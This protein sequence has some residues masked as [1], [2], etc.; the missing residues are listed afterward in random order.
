[1]D[2]LV[3]E[4]QN[5]S[6]NF[7]D[8]DLETI[9]GDGLKG[10]KLTQLAKVISHSNLSWRTLK[11]ALKPLWCRDEGFTVTP[12]GENRFMFDLSSLEIHNRVLTRRPWFL[13]NSI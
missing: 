2:F 9:S 1:M 12:M 11:K 5:L 13:K 3:A 8:L 6:S 10:S 7:E 4:T